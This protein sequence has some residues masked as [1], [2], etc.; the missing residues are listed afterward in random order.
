[1]NRFRFTF[2]PVDEEAMTTDEVPENDK[3]VEP[4][5]QLDRIERKLDEILRR[6]PE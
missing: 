2:T 3:P 5:T 1:M 6:L 4:E